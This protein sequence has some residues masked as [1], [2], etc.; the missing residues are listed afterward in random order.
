ML[1][2]NREPAVVLG[3]QTVCSAH[4]LANRRLLGLRERSPSLL[5]VPLFLHLRHIDMQVVGFGKLALVAVK[6]RA[7]AALLLFIGLHRGENF[8]GLLKV[9][10]V[11]TQVELGFKNAAA[12]VNSSRP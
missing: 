9:R 8:L 1:R 10:W 12:L 4:A 2:I 11:L 6:F 3:E 7:I 5:F